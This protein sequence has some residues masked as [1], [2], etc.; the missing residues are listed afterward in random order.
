[1]HVKDTLVRRTKGLFIS[2]SIV[3]FMTTMGTVHGIERPW[4]G[5]QL[6]TKQTFTSVGNF[7]TLSFMG[8]TGEHQVHGRNCL[9]KLHYLGINKQ[10]IIPPQK[11]S[12][13][14]IL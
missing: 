2:L 3:C 12:V 6:V 10:T 1:M 7:N 11:V 13:F 5:Y 4:T 8:K 9:R 14:N